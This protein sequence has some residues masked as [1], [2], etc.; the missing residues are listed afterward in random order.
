MTIEDLENTAKNISESIFE[1]TI[2]AINYVNSVHSAE[3]EG[4]LPVTS[5]AWRMFCN[6]IDTFFKLNAEENRLFENRFLQLTRNAERMV[7]ITKEIIDDII[8]L[9]HEMRNSVLV[10]SHNDSVQGDTASVRCNNNA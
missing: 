10:R 5:T 2:L 8:V 9:L 7:C 3:S 1:S 6:D 4:S